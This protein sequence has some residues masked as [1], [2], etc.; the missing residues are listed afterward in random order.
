VKLT[1]LSRCT[2]KATAAL[3]QK[4]KAVAM[5]Y[6]QS[7]KQLEELLTK[8]LGSLHMLES[9][10]IR[11]EAA[12]GDIEVGLSIFNLFVACCIVPDHEII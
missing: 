12:V 8:R 7:R 1:I 6:L 5:S 3:H 10:F 9:T 11:V 2:Q 4:H